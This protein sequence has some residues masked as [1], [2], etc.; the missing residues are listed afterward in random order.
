MMG[1]DLKSDLTVIETTASRNHAK[2]ELIGNEFVITDH[3][4]N[5]T[6]IKPTGGPEAYIQKQ[7]YT[8]KGSGL[9]CLGLSVSDPEAKQLIQF[10]CP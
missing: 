3:S 10:A 2:I 8:L 6:Y 1:R 9:I 5:G 7:Q 4:T